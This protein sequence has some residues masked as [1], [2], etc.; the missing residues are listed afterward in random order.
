MIKIAGN[1]VEI[2]HFPD[3]A[4]LLKEDV[5]SWKAN[6]N[7]NSI[8]F[9]WYFENNEELATLQFLAAHFKEQ[10]MR[11]RLFMPYIP[12][13]RQDRRKNVED[14]HILKYFAKIINAMGF[15]SIRVLDP[16]SPVAE[17]LFDRLSILSPKEYIEI[18]IKRVEKAEGV[19]PGMFYPDEGSMK[20][21]SGMVTLPYMFGIK[22]RD[23]KT[24]EISGISVEGKVEDTI[25]SSVL[26]CDDICSYGG[27]VYYSSLKLKE[28]G[29]RNIYL[30]VSHCENS[31][32]KGKFGK[33][34]LN[35][36]DTGLIKKVYTT[37]SL[38][39]G[40]DERIEV[41]SI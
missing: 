13:A 14:I 35:L 41:I 12:N 39:T 8:C 16:H 26:I 36:L 17:A 28:L 25:N 11:I 20:R 9:E 21:Y 24:G 23:W 19:F 32:L 15:D 29:V 22:K 2:K 4:L 6:L 34:K 37:N 10:G 33:E 30:Y 1:T 40:S 27:T 7:T 18:A 5:D 31:I 38:Y 3:G